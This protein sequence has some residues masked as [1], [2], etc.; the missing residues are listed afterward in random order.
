MYVEQTGIPS[1]TAI[2]WEV[3]GK[4]SKPIEP[5]PNNGPY[6]ALPEAVEQEW[7]QQKGNTWKPIGGP[8]GT[9]ITTFERVR[10]DIT[11]SEVKNKNVFEIDI[12]LPEFAQSAGLPA[13]IYF[14][15]SLTSYA[16]DFARTTDWTCTADF[17]GLFSQGIIR[18]P[19]FFVSS[20]LACFAGH[21]TG[22]LIDKLAQ[23]PRLQFSITAYTG[24]KAPVLE[25]A[26]PDLFQL[27]VA[28]EVLEIEGLE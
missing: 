13:G 6:A 12:P 26:Q 19:L 11:P 18:A 1:G 3:N 21:I 25:I 5:S 27:D 2:S 17:S 16:G 9:S 4:Q 10:V 15:I 14:S 24:G 20:T 7:D 22:E 23:L 8:Q 28:G